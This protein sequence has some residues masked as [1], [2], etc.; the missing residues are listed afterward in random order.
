M[1]SPLSHA[2]ATS[3]R[4]K[5]L[6]VLAMV[7]GFVTLF[8]GG[9]ILFGADQAREL[10]GDYVPFV[11]WFNFL[12]GFFYVV[13]AGCIWLGQ[14]RAFGLS[15]LI[16]AATALAALVFGLQVLQGSAFEMRTVGALALRTGFWAVIAFVLYKRAKRP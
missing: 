10:A 4:M 1:D 13:A 9:T 8:S 14:S 5:G 12:A 3:T 11:V 2:A 15:V 7:F 6:A 16:A